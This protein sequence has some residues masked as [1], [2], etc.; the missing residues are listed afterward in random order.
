MTKQGNPPDEHEEQPRILGKLEREIANS[1]SL[2]DKL[3]AAAEL[4]H[5][6]S[7]DEVDDIDECLDYEPRSS[8]SCGT[9]LTMWIGSKAGEVLRLRLGAARPQADKPR[10]D[11]GVRALAHVHRLAQLL[12]GLDLG[13]L[14]VLDENDPDYGHTARQCHL[15][16]ALAQPEAAQLPY[17]IPYRSGVVIEDDPTPDRFMHGITAIAELPV[18]DGDPIVDVVILTRAPELFVAR[19]ERDAITIRGR[20]ALPGWGRSL[21]VTGARGHETLVCVT[22]SGEL[23]EWS[24]RSLRRAPPETAPTYEDRTNLL[25]TAVAAP[26]GPRARDHAL[27]IG[28]SDGLYIRRARGGRPV[29]VAVTRSA[30]LSIATVEVPGHGGADPRHYVAL[31]LEDGRLRVIEEHALFAWL[32]GQDALAAHDFR[33]VLG[34]A[35]L[36][37]ELLGSRE[38]MSRFVLAGLRNHRLR[39]FHV[40][41]RESL[42]HGVRALWRA[43]IGEPN[44][45]APHQLDAQLATLLDTEARLRQ[46]AGTRRDQALRYLLVDDV[47]PTWTRVLGTCDPRI[48]ARACEIAS[49]ADDKV[50]Y[51]LSATMGL[52]AGRDA[53][54][55]IQLSQACLVA[56]PQ[57]DTQPGARSY[58]IIS[59]VSM[60]VP[61]TAS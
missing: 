3:T 60:T 33:I 46:P 27:L 10:F 24:C 54:A 16:H 51:R 13:Y 21:T 41:S 8:T 55:L 32:D 36:T 18:D 34:D 39:L 2:L 43:A 59:S 52:L 37:L 28:A 17:R 44:Q 19:I 14:L 20:Y 42:L 15:G 45:E 9:C 11:G 35:V 40:R 49:G 7:F 56:M 31:G 48:V 1:E 25:P 6:F 53:N 38:L 57:R 26:A 30:V 4:H 61:A 5:Q 22:R 47:L 12:V 50:L 58:P 29:H 23:R